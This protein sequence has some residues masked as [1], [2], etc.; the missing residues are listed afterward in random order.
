VRIGMYLGSLTVAAACGAVIGMAMSLVGRRYDVNFVVA[1]CAYAILGILD[2]KV[3]VE[4]AEKLETRPAIFIC[5]HQS[6]VDIV[7]L[8]KV[9]PLR[10]SIVAKKSIQWTPLGPFMAMSGTVFV[11]RGNGPQAVRS[12]AVAGEKMKSRGTSLWMFPEGTR[13]SQEI[14]SMRPFKKGAFHLAVQAGIPI[15]PVVIENYWRLYHPGYFGT[16]TVKVRVLPPVP[17]T[18]LGTADVHDL[19]NRL[20]DQMLITLREISVQ[21]P[22]HTEQTEDP[23]LPV[24]DESKP[25]SLSE[26][27]SPAIVEPT[28]EL[29][30]ARVESGE[31]F[32]S[33]SVVSQSSTRIRTEGSENGTET[34]EDEGMVLVGRPL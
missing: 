5:N 1:R 23:S 33:N 4:G 22:G 10:T 27:M 7:V 18:D 3:E 17:T 19:A 13:T 32:M 25:G 11:D 24:P 28:P 12:L 26:P 31:S 15:V 6:M 21:V 14:P 9:F 16:G 8:A 34:E 2:V 30:Q 29:P 20:R